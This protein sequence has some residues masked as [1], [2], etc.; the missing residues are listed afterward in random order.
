[1]GAFN[2]RLPTA[3]LVSPAV[4]ST[5]NA[6][7]TVPPYAVVPYKLTE[8]SLEHGW[9]KACE[10]HARWLECEKRGEFPGYTQGV[11]ELDVYDAEDQTEIEAELAMAN[12]DGTRASV[13]F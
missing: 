8:R 4:P 3:K 6:V 10:W 7:E 11:E 1:M 13:D 5:V 9:R 12:D 2:V